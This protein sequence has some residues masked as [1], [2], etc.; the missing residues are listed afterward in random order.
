MYD[1]D[2]DFNSYE[3]ALS[4]WCSGDGPEPSFESDPLDC[5]VDEE[6]ERRQKQKKVVPF[7]RVRSVKEAPVVVTDAGEL[8]KK[9]LKGLDKIRKD[10][11]EEAEDTSH[12]L[13]R[14]G[15]TEKKFVALFLLELDMLRES[16]DCH[17]AIKDYLLKLSEKG[18]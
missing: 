12:V 10:L 18:R 6:L 7:S 9:P 13:F 4:D 14:L 11:I 1:D 17:P 3:Q 16:G 5:L 8:P 15:E 2:D